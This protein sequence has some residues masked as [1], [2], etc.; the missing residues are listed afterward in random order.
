MTS[1]ERGELLR[2]YR[3]KAELL[4]VAEVDLLSEAIL[5]ELRVREHE[6][7]T[8]KTLVPMD[9]QR[10]DFSALTTEDWKALEVLVEI[11]TAVPG[12]LGSRRV[13][14]ALE[15][16]SAQR[17]IHEEKDLPAG[18]RKLLRRIGNAISKPRKLGFYVRGRRTE[19]RSAEIL[20]AYFTAR[21]LGTDG[22]NSNQRDSLA[23]RVGLRDWATLARMAKRYLK[24]DKD[25]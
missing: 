3:C 14:Y 22:L 5:T 12:A 18:L 16:L 13:R 9:F 17:L 19:A 23:E 11:L 2:A 15:W 25:S 10:T 6:R 21:N 8:G 7:R 1:R 24:A 4:G 20:R